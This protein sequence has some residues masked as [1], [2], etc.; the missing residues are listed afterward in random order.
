[1]TGP[2]DPAERAAAARLQH[3]CPHWV[4]LYG[5]WTRL[6][7]AFPRFGVPPGTIVSAPSPGELVEWMRTTELETRPGPPHRPGGR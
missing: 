3:A 5:A 4:I 7:F 2:Y 6:F 1:M